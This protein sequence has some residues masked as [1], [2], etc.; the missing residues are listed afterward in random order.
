MQKLVL[1]ATGLFW[2]AVAVFA[3]SGEAGFEGIISKR[4]DAPYVNARSPTWIK[5]KHETTDE[6][7]IVGYTDPKGSRTGFGALLMGYYDSK[8]ALHYAGGVGSWPAGGG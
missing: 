8:G 2:L 1:F 5:I 6:F 7:L 3:A 4:V